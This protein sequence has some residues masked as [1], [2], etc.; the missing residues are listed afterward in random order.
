MACEIIEN[1]CQSLPQ[2]LHISLCNFMDDRSVF[3]FNEVT[4]GESPDGSG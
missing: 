2:V 3:C 4:M 1:V